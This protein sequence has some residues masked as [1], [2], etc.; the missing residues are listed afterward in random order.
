MSLKETFTKFI[1][2]PSQIQM[3]FSGLKGKNLYFT[4]VGLSVAPKRYFH[5]CYVPEAE[6]DVYRVGQYNA[7]ASYMA[8]PD[9]NSLYV[10][11]SSEYEREE[12]A[13]NETVRFLEKANL[14]TSGR[15]VE[16]IRLRTIF[17]AYPVFDFNY[18]N[19]TELLMRFL[20]THDIYPLGRFARW[21][22]SSMG[23]DMR[24]AMLLASDI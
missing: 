8:P 13:V 18:Q 17:D 11:L 7:V 2:L 22:H 23:E 15:D 4:D 1:S 16:Y 14:I 19:N 21:K 12:N 5:W 9:K 6:Y 3:A 20:H 24:D 10:E